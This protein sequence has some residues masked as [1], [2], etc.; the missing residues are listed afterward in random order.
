MIVYVDSSA[1]VRSYLPDEPDHDTF[2]ELVAGPTT[3]ITGSWTRIE[4]TGS[5]V[6]AARAGR[7]DVSAALEF[8]RRE[9]APGSGPLLVVDVSQADI[10][11]RALQ[12]VRDTGIR[13]MD[14][15]HLACAAI[16]TDALREPGE[17]RAFATRDNAQADIA[18]SLGFT[19]V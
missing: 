6:R 4:V 8:F 10:E 5:L 17:E 14:A 2:R 19:I 13:S 9:T 16:A 18:R 12:I 15:W 11:G 3:T 1:V 7:T